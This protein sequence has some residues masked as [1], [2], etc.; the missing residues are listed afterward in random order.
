[1]ERKL[2]IWKIDN[3]AYQVDVDY[4]L[5]RQVTRP[6]RIIPFVELE[7]TGTGYRRSGKDGA[8][9]PYMVKLDPQGVGS[10]YNIPINQLPQ[11]DSELKCDRKLLADRLQGK[12]PTIDIAGHPF[13]VDLR[14]DLLRPKDDFKTMGIK[15]S[16]LPVD[17][18]N[19]SFQF[20]YDAQE[21]LP[22]SYDPNWKV[23]PEGLMAIE[24]PREL[25]LDPIGTLNKYSNVLKEKYPFKDRNEAI[26][27]DWDSVGLTAV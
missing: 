8:V 21:H 19:S 13:F 5:L 27:F 18:S 23:A 10:K 26:S 15:L 16:Q 20:F 24:I 11:R 4:G 1:M 25:V 6:E 17:R 3:V 2:P 22:V 9:I 14:L 7:D 12:L